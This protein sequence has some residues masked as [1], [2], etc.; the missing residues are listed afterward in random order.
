ML[1]ILKLHRAGFLL[2]LLFLILCCAQPKIKVILPAKAITRGIA[3][4]EWGTADGKPVYLY[5]LVNRSGM[6]VNI[7]SYGATITSWLI[8]A[9]GDSNKNIVLG[10]D[11][12]AGYLAKPPYFGATVGRYGNR[13]AHGK[14]TLGGKSYQLPLNDGKNTL[15]GGVKGFDK[16]VWT[17]DAVTDSLPSLV[18]HYTSRDGE[19][20]FPGNL[21]VRVQFTLDDDGTLHIVYDAATDKPTPLNLTNHSYF[22]LSGNAARNILDDQLMIFA[23]KYTP[24]DSTLIPT[25]T[26][27]PV[28]GTAFDFM[29]ATRIGARI[30][31][32][33]GGYDHNWVLN[34]NNAQLQPVALLTDPVTGRS[35]AVSTTEPGLQ[36][37]TG[38]F[39]DGTLINR[40]GKHIGQHAALC[41]ETQHFPDSP[42]EPGFPSSIVTPGHPYHSETT[43]RLT[44]EN[45]S[46]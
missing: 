36:F 2:P 45:K 7:S 37:Y 9:S 24:V 27:T 44:V 1:S 31:E 35:L 15:H 12:L 46:R 5:S 4:I 3:R 39:L 10:Y 13:I 34:R 41:L 26:L 20:G 28:F 14:F 40:D 42:N 6:T 32:V 33:K 38:N 18:L 21:V 29:H 16:Q 19:E 25:G 30:S 22:N 8:D 23:A 43:Y 17:A 11:S